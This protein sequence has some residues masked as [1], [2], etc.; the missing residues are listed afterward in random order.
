MFLPNKPATLNTITKDHT[1]NQWVE[2]YEHILLEHEKANPGLLGGRLSN[3]I[4]NKIY[5]FENLRRK[6]EELSKYQSRLCPMVT[7]RKLSRK[8]FY[9]LQKKR[10]VLFFDWMTCSDHPHAKKL[11]T[12]VKTSQ[13]GI[14][15]DS[16]EDKPVCYVMFVPGEL[17]TF[18]VGE[19][20]NI[21]KRYFKRRSDV[22]KAK[23]KKKETNERL[24]KMEMALIKYGMSRFIMLPFYVAGKRLDKVNRVIV[25]QSAIAFF[26][27]ELNEKKYY[28]G[29]ELMSHRR[30]F[31]I[32]QRYVRRCRVC[33]DRGE[34]HCTKECWAERERTNSWSITEFRYTK[35]GRLHIA[36]S[37]M[38]IMEKFNR[39]SMPDSNLVFVKNGISSVDAK[40]T[41]NLWG[42]TQVRHNGELMTLKRWFTT[43]DKRV[44]GMDSFKIVKVV[45]RIISYKG[46]WITK[47]INRDWFWSVCTVSE[48]SAA[49]LESLF[50]RFRK[51]DDDN[52]KAKV[53]ID[54]MMK[55]KFRTFPTKYFPLKWAENNSA[56]KKILFIVKR[57]LL[58]SAKITGIQ[59]EHYKKV[60]HIYR[61]ELPRI[62]DLLTNSIKW[63]KNMTEK[64]ERCDDR[65][66]CN[67]GETIMRLEDFPGLPGQIGLLNGKDRTEKMSSTIKGLTT[68]VVSITNLARYIAYRTEPNKAIKTELNNLRTE[69]VIL[70]NEYG[71]EK[72]KW[73][74][75]RLLKFWLSARD[76][77]LETLITMI[78]YKIGNKNMVY[79]MDWLVVWLT[80]PL[81][82][83]VDSTGHPLKRCFALKHYNTDNNLGRFY[84]GFEDARQTSWVTDGFFFATSR[85]INWILAKCTSVKYREL[86]NIILIRSKKNPILRQAS[87]QGII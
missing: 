1:V 76:D 2:K 56:M 19:T 32:R 31:R 85:D 84:G 87:G 29:W 64:V 66:I 86:V 9:D 49:Q 77:D 25:E 79:P 33:Q 36:T 45:R 12:L 38:S 42:L 68:T 16:L 59:Y 14:L 23:R 35:K 58:K 8:F 54:K 51:R 71:C 15:L 55:G 44:R 52:T 78:L 46:N 22:K 17:G 13:R 73:P 43:R 30:D 75:N 69:E 34:K 62:C 24:S 53:C 80:N 28:S 10:T 27:P 11:R 67:N 21:R 48:V 5:S 20:M 61:E 47:V 39:G 81:H 74:F 18:Y 50:L 4:G 40:D 82:E 3:R 70:T 57:E 83:P 72:I 37:L 65:C 63:I 41:L 26:R 6:E 60:V 7:Q